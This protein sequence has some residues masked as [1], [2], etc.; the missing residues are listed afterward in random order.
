MN[1][2]AIV[3]LSSLASTQSGFLLS[4]FILFILICREKHRV[5]HHFA[6]FQRLALRKWMD[7]RLVYVWCYCLIC[8]QGV[9]MH[10]SHCFRCIVRF[11]FVCILCVLCYH[12]F[13]ES[14]VRL[15]LGVR[16]SIMTG[17][18]KLLFSLSSIAAL[19]CCHIVYVL[20]AVCV[21]CALIAWLLR[22]LSTSWLVHVHLLM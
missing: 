15:N 9:S 21:H 5:L 14:F 19:P 1:N 17:D 7:A 11:F 16:Y 18:N 10:G 3:S 12:L 2:V 13:S 20:L 22:L 8:V 4:C 6:L